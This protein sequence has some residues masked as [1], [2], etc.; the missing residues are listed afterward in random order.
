M[1]LATLRA[2]LAK[3]HWI[4]GDRFCAA[5]VL[6]G[7]SAFYL[8]QFGLIED[9]PVLGPYIERCKARPAWLRAQG[10]DAS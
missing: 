1:M 4:L 5:D 10:F 9:D 7:T 8:K 3:G 6:I 2:E